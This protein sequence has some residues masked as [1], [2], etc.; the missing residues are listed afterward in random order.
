MTGPL[1]R[2][3]PTLL[4]CLLLIVVLVAPV[5]AQCCPFCGMQGQTL[6]QEVDLASMVIYGKLTNAR[7]K[8]GDDFGGGETDLILDKD[9]GIIK[10]H[11]WLAGKKIVTIPRYV[12]TDKNDNS[13]FLIFGDLFRGQIDPYRGMPVKGTGDM[14]KYLKGALAVRKAK[15]PERLKFFFNY[16]QNE[17]IEIANDALKEF[18]NAPYTEFEKMS[19]TLPADKV[20]EWLTDKNTP[21]YRIGLYASIV[22][23]ASKKKDE[24]ARLLRSL[25]QDPENRVS[26]GVDGI[27][28]GQVILQP[29]EG[30]QYIKGILSNNPKNDFNY[31]YAALRSARFFADSRP[32]VVAHKDVVEAVTQLLDQGDIAD[33][34]IEDLRKW[35]CWEL[36]KRILELK[37]RESHDLPVMRRAILRFCLSSPD[38]AAKKYVAAMRKADEDM[39]TSAEELLKL[40]QTSPPKQNT[41]RSPGSN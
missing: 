26:S 32:D 4:S 31:R 39:V 34:A 20:A 6:T 5:P 24:H 18:G 30:W 10:S 8:V 2:R 9:D 12:P 38:A 7:P 17:D 36:T 16:L 15:T 25:V 37:D 23:H 21:A 3:S 11:S 1:V 13:R 29:K 14:P 22:A 35:K 19:A 41:P 40:E 33:L 27:L 28:A